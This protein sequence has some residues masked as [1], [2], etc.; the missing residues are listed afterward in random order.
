SVAWPSGVGLG[1]EGMRSQM[2]RGLARKVARCSRS[3]DSVSRARGSLRQ[4]PRNT[5]AGVGK[6]R[7]LVTGITGQDGSYLAELLVAEGYEVWGLVRG[8]DD[9]D[10]RNLEAVRDELRFVEGDL[11]EPASLRG[12]LRESRPHQLYH[13]AAPTF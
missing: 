7:A 13:L 12:A 11:L 8:V 1:V 10:P 5:L 6:R 3:C 9:A 2:K 4:S